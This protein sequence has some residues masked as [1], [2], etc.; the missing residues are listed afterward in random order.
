MFAG[1]SGAARCPSFLPGG[2]VCVCVFVFVL[3]LQL[4]Y[5]DPLIWRPE[6][7]CAKFSCPEVP[8]ARKSRPHVEIVRNFFFFLLVSRVFK[9]YF[10]YIPQRP[11]FGNH[12]FFFVS[13]FISI[14]SVH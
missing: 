11:P 12:Q 14:L 5:G 7:P 13:E 3:Q 4:V 8:P 2:G 9:N 1:W 10:V 6:S